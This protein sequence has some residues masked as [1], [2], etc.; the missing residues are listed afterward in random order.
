M[1]MQSLE[2]KTQYLKVRKMDHLV[3]WAGKKLETTV[4]LMLAEKTV[5]QRSV[6]TTEVARW[7]AARWVASWEAATLVERMVGQWSA[8]RL[9]V[10][11]TAAR[12]AAARTVPMK[13]PRNQH[14]EHLA[15]P[16]LMLLT[17]RWECL[18]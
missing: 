8:A 4:E 9:A 18:S 12:L 3:N 6:V 11:R 14:W 17:R 5:E 13:P 2:T 10:A 16:L 15:R 1:V 7:E